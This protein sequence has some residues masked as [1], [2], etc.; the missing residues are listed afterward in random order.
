ME[1]DKE[2]SKWIWLAVLFSF[3][4]RLD[5][6]FQKTASVYDTPLQLDLFKYLDPLCRITFQKDTLWGRKVFYQKEICLKILS[7][8]I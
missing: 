3:L 4:K 8:W 2:I 6:V 1:L 5:F 7:F